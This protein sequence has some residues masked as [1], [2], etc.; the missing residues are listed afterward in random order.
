MPTLYILCGPAGAG[1]TTWANNFIKNTNIKYV[2]RDKIRFATGVDGEHYFSN[3]NAVF[4]EFSNIIAQNL[5]DGFD[6]IADATHISI[7]SRKK[8]TKAIDRYIKDYKIIY[9][10][11]NVD[12]DI[13]IKHNNA[14]EGLAKVPNFV[15][16]NMVSKFSPPDMDEDSRA[17]DIIEVSD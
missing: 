11:F 13:C 8:L 5:I 12:V 17:I 6:V 9:I 16:Y 2:S 7:T 4:K 3:E 15:I 10:V 14:R 1:K